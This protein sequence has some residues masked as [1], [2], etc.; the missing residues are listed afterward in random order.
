[1]AEQELLLQTAQI[2]QDNFLLRLMSSV[3]EWLGLDSGS[4]GYESL[5]ATL[6]VLLFCLCF[7]RLLRLILVRSTRLK[8]HFRSE[9]TQMVFDE[10]NMKKIAISV[11][12]VAFYLLLPLAFH[13]DSELGHFVKK[14]LD[15]ILIWMLTA[16][17]NTVLKTVFEVVR[18]RTNTGAS[19]LKGIMQV[20]QIVIWCI[21]I[22]IMISVLVGKSPSKLLTGLGASLAILSFVFKDTI[23]NFVSG[24]LLINDKMLKVGDWI[25]VPSSGIDGEIIDLGLNVVKVRNWDNTVSTTT[26]YALT[27][28]TF[29]NWQSMIA[30]GGR[31][32]ARSVDIDINSI[33]FASPDLLSRVATTVEPMK[34]Y[35]PK[36]GKTVPQ[37]VTNMELFRVYI[38]RYID[39]QPWVNTSMTRMVRELQPSDMGA[40]LQVYVFTNTTVW[41]EYERIQ[42]E[43]FEHIMA[44]APLFDIRIFQRPSGSD[45][46]KHTD[47]LRMVDNSDDCK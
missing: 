44:I 15:L 20:I 19:P 1:M 37:A 36:E 9:R 35:A 7:W 45:V 25:E 4:G 28:G 2:E 16:L 32:I 22:I 43:L 33:K 6:I 11:S 14:A 5:A 39:A 34:D 40:P 18:G 3:L 41:V 31:R 29:K 30:S 21:G 27:Q 10:K 23:L 12:I 47:V 42:A 13:A 8:G 26:P 17:A 46:E 24:I 38:K